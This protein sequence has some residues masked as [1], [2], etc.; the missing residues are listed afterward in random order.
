MVNDLEW[1][2]PEPASF[3]EEACDW[4]GEG[5]ATID[6][7]RVRSKQKL[8]ELS[9]CLESQTFGESTGFIAFGSL[10]RLEFTDGSD[11]DWTLLVNG[12]S[13]LGQY[14]TSLAIKRS[15]EA[16]DFTKPGPSGLFGGV[17]SSFE[18]IHQ[19]G[20]LEDTNANMTRRLLLLLESVAVEGD[21]VRQGVLHQLLQRYVRYGRSV[22]GS[23]AES[24]KPP[25][26][27]LNDFVRFW[28]TM[29]VDYDA[30]KWLA[31]DEKWAL[32]NA[33][34]RFSRKLIFVKGLLLGLDCQLSPDAWPW[35]ALPADEFHEAP[36]ERLQQ[37]LQRLIELPAID[38]VCRTAKLVNASDSL[39]EILLAYDQFLSVLADE[40]S[41]E[42]LKTLRFDEAEKNALFSDLRVAGKKFGNALQDLLFRSDDKLTAL[43]MDYGV[44]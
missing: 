33:K 16:A 18:L 12:P 28:R 20:G 30:K 2:E 38:S 6:A 23:K 8:T 14:E 1:N 26:F 4:L 34:L 29:A 40:S 36:E 32:R 11:L 31:P 15:L 24:L 10:A 19:I 3:Y 41:R 17:S 37:G 9:A 35:S 42:Q 39:R 22:E 27:L 5:F 7:A 21:I 25:R 13:D 44:F 43:A